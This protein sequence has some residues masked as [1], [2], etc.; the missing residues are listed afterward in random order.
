ME[1]YPDNESHL[2]TLSILDKNGYQYVGILH[3]KDHIEDEPEKPLKKPHWHFVITF[4]RQKDL[5][6]L[7]NELE[8]ESRFLEPCRNKEGAQRY[9]LHLDHPLKAQYNASELFGP[10]S[11]QVRC[12]CDSG[13]TEEEKVLSLLTLL[14][15]MPKPCTYRRFL[16][17]CCE[18][19]LY[20]Q[21]RHL[22]SSIKYLLDEH[23]GIGLMDGPYN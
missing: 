13:S 7:A 1:L 9:L 16:T 23:N 5:N 3:D 22:G 12:I 2:N 19:K 4:T 21:Y 20:A 14:D 8:I 17:A 11:D 15:T 10:L 18:A 6:P